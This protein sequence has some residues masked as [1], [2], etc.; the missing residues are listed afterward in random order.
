M[1]VFDTEREEKLRLRPDLQ[2][3]GSAAAVV[4]RLP[5][6]D[7]GMASFKNRRMTAVR[8]QCS[9]KH[10]FPRKNENPPEQLCRGAM[11]YARRNA[12]GFTSSIESRNS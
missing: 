3:D 5:K 4:G 11:K 10:R 1:A 7:A 12:R 2:V 6:N 9:G 8:P